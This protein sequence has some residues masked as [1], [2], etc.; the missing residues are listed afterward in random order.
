M[1]E[2]TLEQRA[3][4][5]AHMALGKK[6]GPE[7]WWAACRV[8]ERAIVAAGRMVPLAY[9]ETTLWT[10]LEMAGLVMVKRKMLDDLLVAAA[11]HGI[12]K[13]YPTDSVRLKELKR[14]FSELD[15]ALLRG[16]RPQIPRDGSVT[17]DEAVA[18]GESPKSE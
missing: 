14:C 13:P 8:A 12:V 17:L 15:T 11:A 5:M 2:L 10:V 6:V 4:Q 9:T 7:A 3:S 1:A 18:S 16:A